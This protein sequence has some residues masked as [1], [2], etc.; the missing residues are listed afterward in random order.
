MLRPARSAL[1]VAMVVSALA[2]F[3]FAADLPSE[4]HK[5]SSDDGV[6]IRLTQVDP[7]KSERSAKHRT[8]LFAVV[9]SLLAARRLSQ[10]RTAIRVGARRATTGWWLPGG[11]RAPP[12]FDAA[13][14]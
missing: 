7:G 2:F 1:I 11:E 12:A 14:A 4:N 10:R 6:E 9:L 3:G 13:I 8:T 5:V